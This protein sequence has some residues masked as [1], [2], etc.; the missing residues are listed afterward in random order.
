MSAHSPHKGVVAGVLLE[1]GSTTHSLTILSTLFAN[2]ARSKR[3]EINPKIPGIL[4]LDVV[5]PAM[6]ASLSSSCS[7][8]GSRCNPHL[9]TLRKPHNPSGEAL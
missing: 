7:P 1:E 6:V 8:Q 2:L 3:L 9:A 4:A 5:G